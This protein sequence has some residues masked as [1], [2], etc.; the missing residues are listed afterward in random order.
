[1]KSDLM[2]SVAIVT[3]NHEQYIAQALDSVISQ[4]FSWPYEIIVGDDCSTDRTREILNMYV[5]KYNF[6]HVLPREQNMGVTRNFFD[7]LQHCSGQYI[8][9]LDGDDYWTDPDKLRKQVQY[10][11][12]HKNCAGVAHEYSMKDNVTGKDEYHRYK[13]G[14]YVISDL[15]W[16]RLP[17]QT[18]TLCFRNFLKDTIDN[19]NIIWQASDIIG[20]RTL[21][22]LILLHG[23]IYCFDSNMSV[24]RLN[25]SATSWSQH[26]KKSNNTL[27]S[28]QYYIKLEQYVKV[29]W[30]TR[31]VFL[32]NKC[33]CVYEA[34]QTYKS[35]K[36]G[37]HKERFKA[38]LKLYDNSKLLL[39][40]IIL[41]LSLKSVVY[42]IKS[43]CK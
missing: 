27:K 12:D 34:L 25:S 21:I 18:S 7:V 42:K 19:Y 17:G 2:I 5:E 30:H 38:V 32:W 29:K 40:I 31:V 26:Y 20:D 11:T 4:N 23:Y 10:L 8:A 14:K 15:R 22:L 13:S 9:L 41:Y 16:G 3:Y 35:T 36:N 6:I 37:T 39:F 1:M 33:L 24:Y 28:M 43:R